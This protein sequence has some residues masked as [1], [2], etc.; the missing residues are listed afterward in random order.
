RRAVDD[1]ARADVVLVALDVAHDCTACQHIVERLDQVPVQVLVRAR[2]EGRDP[3]VDP[4]AGVFRTPRELADLEPGY[5][6]R[7][8]AHGRL[9]ENLQFRL[10]ALFHV[11]LR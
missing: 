4:L 10:H 3:D 5:H 9:I 11:S 7:R 6:A 1:I 2:A 8:L